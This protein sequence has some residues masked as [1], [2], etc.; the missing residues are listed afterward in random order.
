MTDAREYTLDYISQDLSNIFVLVAPTIQQLESTH[1]D[2]QKG[3]FPIIQY[4]LY[5]EDELDLSQNVITFNW[6]STI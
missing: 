5:P 6:Q 1:T 3:R 4:F 2:L